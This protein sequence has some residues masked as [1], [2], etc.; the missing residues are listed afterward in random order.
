MTVF[1][2]KKEHDE[3]LESLVK[4]FDNDEL[5]K[6]DL[7]RNQNGTKYDKSIREDFF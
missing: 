7:F 6:Y 4:D 5:C 1:L 3:L 2:S